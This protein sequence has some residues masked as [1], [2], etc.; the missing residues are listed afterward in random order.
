MN[1]LYHIKSTN[2]QLISYNIMTK[3]KHYLSFN[4]ET[5]S[6]NNEETYHLIVKKLY[7]IYNEEMLYPLK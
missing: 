1:H 5:L 2:K 7:I 3:I 4:E 6:F